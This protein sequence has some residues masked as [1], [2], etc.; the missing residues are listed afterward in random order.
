MSA[1]ADHDG[2]PSPLRDGVRLGILSSIKHD[3]ERRG[4]RTARLLVAAGAIGA[5]GAIG[6]TLIVSRH[7][8]GHHP[9]WHL[10]VFSTVWSGLLIVSL[11]VVFLRVRTPS[12]PLARA[13]SIGVLG[14]GLAGICGSIC[15][16]QHFLHW[17]SETGMGA[18]IHRMGGNALGAIC[19]GLV[20]TLFFSLASAFIVGGEPSC[21]RLNAWLPSAILLALLLPGVVL[22]SVDMSF[23]VCAGWLAGTAIGAFL[24]VASGIRARTWLFSSRIGEDGQR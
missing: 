3:V 1:E 10:V 14:L 7:P 6:A 4:G 24:G 2:A 13:A 5:M 16:D 23:V 17:W 15:P 8:F 19:F 11:A 20:T 9:S 18:P 12:L 21:S 22:Q